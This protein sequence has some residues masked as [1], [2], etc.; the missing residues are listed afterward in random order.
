M[1]TETL[2]KLGLEAAA[3]STAIAG[4]RRAVGFDVARML[5]VIRSNG[6]FQIVQS[7]QNSYIS[8]LQ[9]FHGS[10]YLSTGLSM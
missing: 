2:V 6:W 1:L 4:V 8:N 7:F 3:I 5:Y 9:E 10:K